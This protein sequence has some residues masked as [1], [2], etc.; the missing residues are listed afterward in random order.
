SIYDCTG[1]I[2]KSMVECFGSGVNHEAQ[3]RFL[4]QSRLKLSDDQQTIEER[5]EATFAG[6]KKLN[7]KTTFQ[8]DTK[9]EGA[10][11]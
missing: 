2:E 9:P 6:G 3:L 8:R 5:W 4:Y 11:K 10:K 1:I 7:G